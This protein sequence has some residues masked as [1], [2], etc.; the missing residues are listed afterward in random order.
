MKNP[1]PY[2]D[3]N[4]RY[5]TYTCFLSRRFGGKV[6]RVPLNAGFTCPNL[7][8]TKG[9][10]GCVYCSPAGSGEFGGDPRL[11]IREQFSQ[12]A[13]RMAGKW[14]TPRHIAYFQAR[15]N[16]YAPA[17]TLRRLYE[18]ALACPGVVGLAVATR[19]DCLPD[20]VCGLLGELARRTYLTVELGLQTAHDVTGERINRCHSYADFLEGAGKLRARGVPFGVHLIDGL[21]GE[22]HDMMVE[23]AKRVG[24]L[25]PHLVKIHLLHL[26]EGTA[27]AREYREKPFPLMSRDEYVQTVCDQLEW[28]PSECVIG[29]LT[30]D[31][32]PETLIGPDWSRKK[33]CV[34]NEIDKELA[35]RDSW[36]GKRLGSMPAGGAA[37]G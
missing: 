1:F 26:L 21:P 33:L 23:T 8:G 31:G 18:E 12:V 17:D 35:R 6:S 29:R 3:S 30:G 19:P 25:R 13:A 32:D 34:L 36:Q 15:T 20:E 28:L 7:D 4:K 14:D 11:P 9:R 37:P 22:T 2:S 24:G 10:G 27:L 16:T 5:H